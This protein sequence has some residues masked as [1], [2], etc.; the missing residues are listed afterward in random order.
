[1]LVIV[2][3]DN[4][5][6]EDPAFVRSGVRAGAEAAHAAKVVEVAGRGAALTEAVR[7]ASAGDVIA[8]LGKGNEQGQEVNGEVL[9]FDDRIELSAALEARA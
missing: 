6:T 5:R 4:P 7:M 3:D 8:V 9:P 1:D 2:T